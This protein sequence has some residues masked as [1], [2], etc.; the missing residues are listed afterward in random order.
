MSI[1]VAYEASLSGRRVLVEAAKE[2]GWRQTPLVVVHVAEGVDIEL[3]EAQAARLRD[4]I[5]AVLA[6]AGLSELE[7][8]LQVP[9]GVD[10]AETLLDLAADTGAELVVIGARRRS[11]VG[12]LI[13][14]SVSQTVVLQA[15]VPVLVVN[16]RAT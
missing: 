15:E 3:I 8:A 6:E 16:P 13:L 4:E 10:V 12:K 5:A 9:T 7:W 1:V 11:R 2:A 14:G